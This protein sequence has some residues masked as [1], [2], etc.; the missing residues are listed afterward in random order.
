MDIPEIDSPEAAEHLQAGA[1]VFVDVR[2]PG[3]FGSARIPGAVNPNDGT[4][5]A[6]VADTDKAQKLIVYCYH[7]NMSKGATAYFLEQGFTDVTSLRGGFTVWRGGH[8]IDEAA[9]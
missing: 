9:L 6:F 8:P 7:G 2:D 5:G 1:A 4:I 3:S